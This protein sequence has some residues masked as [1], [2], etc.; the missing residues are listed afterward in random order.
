M[1]SI[2]LTATDQ[3]PE[4]IIKDDITHHHFAWISMCCWVSYTFY[5]FFAGADLSP[6]TL[7]I[8]CSFFNLYLC[9][10][11]TFEYTVIL[12][13]QKDEKGL[14]TLHPRVDISTSGHYIWL[15]PLQSCIICIMLHT[16]NTIDF[17]YNDNDDD[18]RTQ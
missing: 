18:E 7:W 1:L 14:K 16:I 4:K 10:F 17:K 6:L 5:I 2:T 9:C 15:S 8:N 11:T 12:Q 3:K 13:F